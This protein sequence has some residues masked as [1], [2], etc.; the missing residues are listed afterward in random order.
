MSIKIVL[1]WI[2]SPLPKDEGLTC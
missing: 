2:K 1:K